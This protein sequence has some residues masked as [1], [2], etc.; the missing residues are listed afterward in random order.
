[1]TRVPKSV[2]VLW[3]SFMLLA[4]PVMAADAPKI[5]NVVAVKV[6]GDPTAYL[7]QVK[8]LMAIE[9]RLETGATIHVW[10][11]VIAGQDTGLIYVGIEY[12]NIEAYAQGVTKLRADEEYNQV[13]KEM[14]ANDQR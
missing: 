3:M 13:R 7:Q 8:Q 9:K 10:R 5:L 11:A 12:A 6:K 14:Q 4:L 1:M 2:G